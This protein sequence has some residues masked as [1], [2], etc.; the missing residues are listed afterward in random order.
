[1]LPVVSAIVYDVLPHALSNL[2]KLW[3]RSTRL[4][5]KPPFFAADI[6]DVIYYV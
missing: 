4:L 1:M 3:C 6:S 2:A 5:E